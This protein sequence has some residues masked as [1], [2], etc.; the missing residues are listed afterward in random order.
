MPILTLPVAAE[1]FLE[2]RNIR[3]YHI[4]REREYPERYQ[5][6]F[7]LSPDEEATEW[8]FDVRALA[9]GVEPPDPATLIRAVLDRC[10]DEGAPFPYIQTPGP[11]PDEVK[12]APSSQI[13]DDWDMMDLLLALRQRTKT[14]VEPLDEA[15]ISGVVR[16]LQ[17]LTNLD[18]SRQAT[19]E[20]W[21]R[22][23]HA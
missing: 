22:E 18:P 2:H 7:S 6:Q 9:G 11:L 23:R 3:V 13:P 14:L 17:V 19:L 15:H 21:L 12:N 8:Q 20:Q 10:L 4:Y 5:F 16:L 1:I